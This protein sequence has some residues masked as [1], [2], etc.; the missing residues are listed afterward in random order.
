VDVQRFADELPRLFDDFPRSPHPRGRRFDDLVETIDGLGCENNLALLNLAASLLEPGESYVEVGSFKG[1]SLAG[2]MRGNEGDFV[3]IDN[4][5]L[6]DGTRAE[7][8]RNAPGARIL[9]GDAFELLR[10][11]ALAGRRI[12]VYFYDAV[13]D[14]DS[15][16]A[17]LRLVEPHLADRALLVVDDADWERV[18]RATRD[19]LAGQPRARLLVE[20]GGSDRG[21]PHWWEGMQALAWESL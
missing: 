10:G 5:T 12:G 17:A 7:L 13:H 8:E 1:R 16:L 18:A 14:Y 21:L 4:F 3:G 19:Y 9:E 20:V 15:Q 11:G 6:R 2:A